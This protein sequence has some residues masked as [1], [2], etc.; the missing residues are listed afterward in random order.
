MARGGVRSRALAATAGLGVVV[1]LGV[2]GAVALWGAPDWGGREATEVRAGGK[3]TNAVVTL[4]EITIGIETT[5]TGPTATNRDPAV[6]TPPT[7]V[8]KVL[9]P[10]PPPVT[11]ATTVL[12][13][14]TTSVPDALIPGLYVMRPDGRDLVQLATGT[15]GFSWS[16][17]GR[18]IAVDQ[19]GLLRVVAADGSGGRTLALAGTGIHAPGWSTDGSQIAF[20]R[21]A[22]GLFVVP[23]SGSGGP[24]LVDA[25][26]AYHSWT[27]DG[28]LSA[29]RNST[30]LVVYERDGTSRVLATDAWGSVPPAWSPDGRRVA[31]MSNR[32]MI[33]AADG[34]DARPLT[35]PCCGSEWVGSPL[36]WSPDRRRI[37]FIDGPD[38]RAVAVDSGDVTTLVPKATTP[39]WSTDGLRLTFLDYSVTRPDGLS[40]GEVGR[41]DADGG[42]RRIV[43]TL[44]PTLSAYFVAWSGAADRIAVG[45]SSRTGL[46]VP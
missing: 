29:I 1:N 21:G 8:P 38:V 40:N 34:S 36:A 7:T 18:S 13:V 25:H 9:P 4:P 2:G 22:D 5:T 39:T 20:G 6:G 37:A 46:F 31:Y 32:I 12:P 45:L 16:P 33:V 19:G 15:R 35:E 41:A 17:D 30:E 27:P 10:L 23:A 43:F 28:R 14:T 11:T 44:P 26:A 42:N 3:A 24:T